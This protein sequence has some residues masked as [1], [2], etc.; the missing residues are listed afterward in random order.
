MYYA[1]RSGCVKCCP[2]VDLLTLKLELGAWSKVKFSVGWLSTPWV[3]HHYKSHSLQNPQKERA[4]DPGPLPNEGKGKAC[5]TDQNTK[6]IAS[7]DVT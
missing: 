6:K 5:G 7:R 3:E 2:P 4:G 1:S